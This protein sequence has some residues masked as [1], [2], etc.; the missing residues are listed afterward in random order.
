MP[1]WNA[2]KIIRHDKYIATRKRNAKVVAALGFVMLIGTLFLALNPRLILVSYIL[3]LSGFVLFNLGM[4]QVGKWT[5]NPR[6]DQALDFHLKNLPDRFTVVHYAPVGNK[7]VEHVM[8]YPGGAL[9]MTTKEV[10]GQIVENGSKWRRRGSGM[11]RFFSFSGPQLGN[12]SIETEDGI[13]RLEKLLAEKSMEVDV[14]GV[15][16]FLHPQTELEIE[17]PDFPVLHADELQTYITRLPADETF[18]AAE[19]EQLVSILAEGANQVAVGG[20][21]KASAGR[22]T[23]RRRPVKRAPVGPKSNGAPPEAETRRRPAK[24]ASN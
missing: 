21:G 10:D 8:V 11:R 15:V 7:R 12:P 22:T 19:R 16:V 17:N 20:D 6:N 3:M 24:R 14:D 4:Q 5:R 2:M 18:T 1:V 13:N 9:V 23:G